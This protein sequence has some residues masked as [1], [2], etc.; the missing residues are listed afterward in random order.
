MR[1]LRSLVAALART[2]W[3]IAPPA[4]SRR[5]HLFVGNLN[6]PAA[7]H[8]LVFDDES[9]QINVSRTITADSSHSWITFNVRS[10][11][12]L[13]RPHPT[14]RLPWT[15]DWSHPLTASSTI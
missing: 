12:G 9:F 2:C 14:D 1:S 8:S 4:A 10:F 7:I 3:L 15:V 5:H 11:A 13:P 6:M